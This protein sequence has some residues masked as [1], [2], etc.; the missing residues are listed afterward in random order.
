VWIPDANKASNPF[1]DGHRWHALGSNNGV[2]SP[3]NVNL[4]RRH[5]D[6]P[7]KEIEPSL[8]LPPLPKETPPLV[9]SKP[10]SLS[11]AQQAILANAVHPR[12]ARVLKDLAIDGLGSKVPTIAGGAGQPAPVSRRSAS[13][14]EPFGHPLI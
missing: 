7:S 4:F 2:V 12:V 1:R 14:D 3:R 11:S 6:Q 13:P 8:E 10:I 9:L 5:Q